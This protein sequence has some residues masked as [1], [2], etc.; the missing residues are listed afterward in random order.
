MTSPV[1]FSRMVRLDEIGRMRFPAHI[2]ANEAERA[3]LAE[4]FK[5]VTLDRLEAEYDL[6]RDG[7]V[8]QASGTISASLSQPRI[9]T[10]E[11]VPETV[12]EAF[13]I[14]FVPEEP[15]AGQDPEEE[16]ELDTDDCDIL[17]YDGAR[18]DIGEAVAETLAL[19]VEPYP[20]SANA[21]AYLREL[22]VLTEEQAGPFAALA[23]LREKAGK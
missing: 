2:E 3:A 14:R 16:I 9:A 23:A 19:H 5:F 6:A 13:S 4:R 1:E 18:L 7:S 20:R 8:I 22:G 12:K 10:G 17:P 11:P 21:D 15:R